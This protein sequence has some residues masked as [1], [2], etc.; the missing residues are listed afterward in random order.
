[1][2]NLIINTANKTLEIA[3]IKDGKSFSYLSDSNIKHNEAMI[4]QLDKI[5]QSQNLD[6]NEIDEF[7]VVIGPGSF[8]GIRVGIATIKAFRD[9]NKC[10][11]KSINNLKYLYSLATKQ[12]PDIEVVAILGSADSFFV[13]RKVLDKLYIYDRNLTL[14]ELK[15]VSNNKQIGMFEQCED[16]DCF[17]V[18]PDADVLYQCMLESTDESLTPVYYQLSQ[19]EREEIK[20]STISIDC[21]SS[22]DLDTIAKIEE[23][24]LSFNKI[25][26]QDFNHFIES[27]NHKIFVA[28]INNVVVGFIL[29]EITDEINIYTVAVDK[30]YRNIG[31]ATQLVERAKEFAKEVGIDKLSLEVSDNNLR[32]YLLYEKL[33]FAVRRI[34]KNYYADKSNAIEM[35][36]KV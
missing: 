8:T 20:H 13:A 34:R 30:N 35:E 22:N 21:V 3:L 19:A 33:G 9:V 5:L 17:V 31:L 2:N 32:A 7:G 15:S 27:E 16:V 26:K 4:P 1:M 36:L 6:I 23:K 24:S 29:L 14:D 12:N 11:A 25:S 28:K 10:K 18:R